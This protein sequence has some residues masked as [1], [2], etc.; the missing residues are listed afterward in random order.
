VSLR[1]DLPR[2]SLI[3]PTYHPGQVP[4]EGRVSAEFAFRRRSALTAV[5][6]L[7]VERESLSP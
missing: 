7:L 3:D 4:G 6:K 5:F 1:L 2:R